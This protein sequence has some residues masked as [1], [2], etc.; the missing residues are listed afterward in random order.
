MALILDGKE[1]AAA[2]APKLRER[3]AALRAEGAEPGLA[4]VL[5]G[6]SRP[7]VMYASFME[8]EA[9]A[10]GIPVRLVKKDETVTEEEMIALM[11]ELNGD[12][13]V[14]GI[15]MMMPLPKHI[16]AEVVIEAMDPDKD[17]DGLTTANMGR[18]A[19]GKDGLFPCTP[20][21]C[22][23][24]LRHYGIPVDGKRAVVIGR[25]NVVGGPAAQLLQRENATVTVCHSHTRDMAEITR[26]ADILVAAL[27]RAESVTADMIRPGAVVIDVGIN[28]AGGKTVGDVA[29][30]EAKT[31]AGAITPVPGGV[32]SVTTA[33]VIEAVIRAAEIQR[34]RA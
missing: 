20:R 4:I 14:S 7:S 29:Y 9:A 19:A 33:M 17:I 21:A 31:V 2:L 27:G 25:S 15:L 22:M 10:Y 16:R 13:A 32:G 34:G 24:I 11:D 8:K 18:L 1:T 3:L 6:D 12:P 30:E 5:A 28:R 26:Q 23:E